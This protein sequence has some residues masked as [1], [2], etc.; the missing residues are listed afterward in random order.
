M[1]ENITNAASIRRSSVS[2][3][4][5]SRRRATPSSLNPAL[6]AR[7][8]GGLPVACQLRARPG[9]AAADGT[10]HDLVCPPRREARTPR[11]RC[12]CRRSIRSWRR[13]TPTSGTRCWPTRTRGRVLNRERISPACRASLVARRPRP[14]RERGLRGKWVIVN[15]RSSVD[16]FLTFSSRARLARTGLAEVQ[17]PRRQR[18]RRTTPTPPS[19]ASSSCAPNGPGCSATPRTRTG[20]GRHDGRR[21]ESAPGAAEAVW[22]AAVARVREEVADMQALAARETAGTA[23]EPWDYLYYAEK[24]RKA[25]I[26]PRPERAQAV[27]RARATWWPPRSGRP[28]NATTSLHGDHRSGAGVPSRR[29][30]L[31]GHRGRRPA[32]TADC[33]TST[34]SRGPASG[35]APGRRATAS[36]TNGRRGDRDLVEQ[37]QLRQGAPRRAGA[38]LAR[39]CEDAVPRVRPRAARAAAGRHVSGAGET[40]RDFVELPSQVNEQ[41][42][43]TRELL[44][45][46]ARHYETGEPIPQALRREGRAVARSS[47]RATR[48]SSTSRRRILDMELHTTAGWRLRSRDVRAR[49]AGADRD[50]ARDRAAPPAAAIRSPVRQ[51]LPIRP[52]T[53]ATS[54]PT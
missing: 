6:F 13:F 54:G 25:Q 14:P 21:P 53:T 17:E 2:G 28:S 30:G 7:H 11:R 35:L 1:T 3:S 40:P 20:D 15:T 34:T 47:T 22:P 48:L 12:S 5:S 23:I 19:P 38:D 4:R 16:P 42:L 51:R 29:A 39:R 8:R 52:A 33:S 31:G 36:Q 32:R 24:V 45:R 43:L 27:F 26:R 41:W 37:Q 18:R 9:S 46:F 10:V 49:R 50:A 44:D